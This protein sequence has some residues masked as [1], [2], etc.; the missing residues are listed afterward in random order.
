MTKAEKVGEVLVRP[1]EHITWEEMGPTLMV[2][3]SAPQEGG[4]K[5]RGGCRG[6]LQWSSWTCRGEGCIRRD[7]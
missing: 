7:R 3:D 4:R 5:H 2:G 6:A 1:E